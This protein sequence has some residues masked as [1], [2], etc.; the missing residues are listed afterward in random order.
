M[1]QLLSGLGGFEGVGHPGRGTARQRGDEAGNDLVEIPRRER[2]SQAPAAAP[3]LGQ[4]LAVSTGNESE[5]DSATL[6]NLADREDGPSLQ[7]DIEKRSRQRGRAGDA[8]GLVEGGSRPGNGHAN[9]PEFL[10]HQFCQK[11]TI[12]GDEDGLFHE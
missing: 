7:L 10:D 8:E 12:L 3:Q 5:R 4:F 1:G 6:E 11:P 9:M 2:L